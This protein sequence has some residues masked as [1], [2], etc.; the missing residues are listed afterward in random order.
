[1]L[2]LFIF[3]RSYAACHLR[4]MMDCWWGGVLWTDDMTVMRSSSKKFLHVFK[5]KFLTKPIFWM[6]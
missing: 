6:F 1:L 4:V 3:F 5:I 2:S